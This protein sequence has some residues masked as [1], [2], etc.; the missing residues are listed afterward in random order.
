MVEESPCTLLN[1]QLTGMP[2]FPRNIHIPTQLEALSSGFQRVGQAVKV[3][4]NQMAD[5]FAAVMADE[6]EQRK[7]RGS[8]IGRKRRARRAGGR[9]DG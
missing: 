1:Q 7:Q 6:A 3:A 4:A 5:A 9:G 2:G 8:T